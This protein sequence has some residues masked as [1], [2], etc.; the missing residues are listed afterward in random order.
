MNAH[1]LLESSGYSQNRLPHYE[2]TNKAK[3]G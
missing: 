3:L 2:N 1:V